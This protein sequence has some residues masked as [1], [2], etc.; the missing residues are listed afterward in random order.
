MSQ[1]QRVLRLISRSTKDL[2]MLK[3]MIRRKLNALERQNHYEMSHM[4]ELLDADLGAFL[5]MLR[6][7]S[8]GYY[9][10]DVPIDVYYAAGL[11]A[12]VHADCGPCTQLGVNFALK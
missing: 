8:L 6:A 5:K 12:I 1:W 2:I 10:K 4:H 3:W 9:R 7:A 11:T